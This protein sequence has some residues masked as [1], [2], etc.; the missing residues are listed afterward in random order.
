[1]LKRLIYTAVF[2]LAFICFS[3]CGL[4]IGSNYIY[5]N[6]DKYTAGDREI[7]DKVTRINVDYL[8]GNVKVKG[9][10][11]DGISIRETANQNIDPDHQVHSWVDGDTLYVRYCVS[12]DMIN[13]NKI[14][15]SLEITIPGEQELDDF[16]ID[17]SSGNID[18][19]GFAT[20]SLNS[21]A[22]SGNMS[23]DCSAS[24]IDINSSSG[25]VI[26]VQ[27][28]NSVRAQS[29]CR[30]VPRLFEYSLH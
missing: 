9:T 4:M 19:D 28:G 11:D 21:H 26:L 22:S 18:L 30:S 29:A 5:Q 12:T 2:V 25:N 16:I 13:F 3:G 24:V 23:I 1:M 8:S 17:V 7:D 6:G 20:D 10:S 15:K 27:K 14:E